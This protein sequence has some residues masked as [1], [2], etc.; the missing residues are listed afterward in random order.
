MSDDQNF[1]RAPMKPIEWAV[2]CPV[3]GNSMPVPEVEDD[4]AG[5]WHAASEHCIVEC[6]CG[7]YIEPYG[8]SIVECRDPPWRQRRW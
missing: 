5:I 8:A 7:A 3:C 4:D 6:E 1:V 2:E